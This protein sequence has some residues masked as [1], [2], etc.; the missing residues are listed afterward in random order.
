MFANFSGLWALSEST[1]LPFSNCSFSFTMKTA[2]Y[3]I[4]E[5]SFKLELEQCLAWCSAFLTCSMENILRC[6][7]KMLPCLSNL[8]Y[9]ERLAK[10]EILSMKY[11]RM[12]GDMIMIYKV[13][14]GYEPL[15]KH[16]FEVDNNSI[17]RGH[18]FKLKKPP[19]KTTIRQHF[20][21]NRVVNNWNSLPF[22]VVNA[23]S[24]NSFKNKLDKCWENRMYV[25]WK[26]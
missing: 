3:S 2:S 7:C 13:L 8:A 10:I 12:R 24:I 20:F 16:L 5:H 6:A 4:M 22:D 1:F 26:V 25:A 19:F 17:T 15:L 21:N 11:R 23:T 14:N 18:N 9:E